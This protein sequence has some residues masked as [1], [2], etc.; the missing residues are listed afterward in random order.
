MSEEHQCSATG[1]TFSNAADARAHE[2]RFHELQ[3]ECEAGRVPELRKDDVIYVDTELYLWHGRD[4]FR[5]GL[6]QVFECYMD[7]SAGKPTPFVR[8]AQQMNTWHNWRELASMQK[9][10]RAEF[11]KRWAYPDPDDRPEFN[12]G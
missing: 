9:K 7:I 11:G 4:D 6:A 2:A 8:V 12:D 5:G 1:R 10:L 3:A